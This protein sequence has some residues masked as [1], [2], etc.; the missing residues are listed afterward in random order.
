MPRLPKG[1]F[2][3]GA[4]Y[5]VRSASITATDGCRW[6][7]TA[8]KPPSAIASSRLDGVRSAGSRWKRRRGSGSRPTFRP[9]RNDKGVGLARRRVALHWVPYF[10]FK[11]LAAGRP[12]DLRRYRL[13]LEKKSISRQTV[14]HLLS[15]ARC[16]F[17]WCEKRGTGAEERRSRGELLPEDSGATSRCAHIKGR[18]G[19]ARRAGRRTGLSSGLGLA[20]GS[21]GVSWYGPGRVDVQR[22]MLVVSHTKSGKVRRVPLPGRLAPGAALQDR[23]AGSDPRLVGIHQ[24]E[25]GGIQA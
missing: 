13:Q 1:M 14:A 12:D 23:P 3:P 16:L 15:D 24:V 21:A 2:K 9:R 17:R 8:T 10:K 7:G 6:G 20:T 18:A 19:G 5:Y 22:G 11:P 25:C 4:S